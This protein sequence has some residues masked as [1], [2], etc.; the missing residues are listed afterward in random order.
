MLDTVDHAKLPRGRLEEHA[1]DIKSA[2]AMLALE[3]A[4]QTGYLQGD[5]NSVQSARS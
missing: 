5:E 2:A 4:A 3:A 1:C